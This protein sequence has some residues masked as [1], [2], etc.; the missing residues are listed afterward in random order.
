MIDFVWCFCSWMQKV[1]YGRQHGSN[2]YTVRVPLVISWQYKA[3]EDKR[4]FWE[5]E[6]KTIMLNMPS[7]RRNFSTRLE[8]FNAVAS[9]ISTGDIL[10][11][12]FSTNATALWKTCLWKRIENWFA[13]VGSH[14]IKVSNNEKDK[15]ILLACK[16]FWVYVR[17]KEFQIWKQS[18]TLESENWFQDVSLQ[19]H[20]ITIS[21]TRAFIWILLEVS[22]HQYW[23]LCLHYTCIHPL[24][25]VCMMNPGYLKLRFYLLQAIEMFKKVPCVSLLHL[26]LRMELCRWAQHLSHAAIAVT[27]SSS[28]V[29]RSRHLLELLCSRHIETGLQYLIGWSSVFLQI[30]KSV[31]C[32]SWSHPQL[33][34]WKLLLVEQVFSWLEADL[35][36]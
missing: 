4:C 25:F 18:R 32:H 26:V 2:R 15:G 22:T 30:N 5:E 6:T 20:I 34:S 10:P 21:I 31:S 28:W 33:L 24:P 3:C 35:F 16:N 1:L 29:G 7:G 14:P 19:V 17:K 36:F 9:S 27:S 12:H 11:F 23:T 8:R 13:G